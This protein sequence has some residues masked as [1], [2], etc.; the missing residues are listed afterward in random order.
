[1]AGSRAASEE[2]TYGLSHSGKVCE[3]DENGEGGAD[4]GFVSMKPPL[5]HKRIFG[6]GTTYD[7][8]QRSCSWLAIDHTGKGQEDS[9]RRRLG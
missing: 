5:G 7:M 3:D 6:G 9:Q 2:F 8:R 4:A 1:V